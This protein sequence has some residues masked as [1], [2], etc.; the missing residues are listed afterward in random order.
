M[1]VAVAVVAAVVAAEAVDVGIGARVVLVVVVG[2]A[3]SDPLQQLVQDRGKQITELLAYGC[4]DGNC[5][6]VRRLRG[7]HTNGGCRCY[8]LLADLGLEMA[9]AADQLRHR[10]GLSPAAVL[11]PR[12]SNVTPSAP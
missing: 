2:S 4:S 9:A 7:M 1:G 11:D 10:R 12:V 3:V 8:A 5:Q 6:L